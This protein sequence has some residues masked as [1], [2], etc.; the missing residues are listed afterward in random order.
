L[1]KLFPWH[2]IAKNPG[3][4][5]GSLYPHNLELKATKALAPQALSFRGFFCFPSIAKGL[6]K[7]RQPRAKRFFPSQFLFAVCTYS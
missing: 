3:M 2:K 5:P 6:G 1:T 7:E 4:N